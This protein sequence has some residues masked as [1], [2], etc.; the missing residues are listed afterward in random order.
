MTDP[1]DQADRVMAQA[2]VRDGERRAAAQQAARKPDCEDGPNVPP[3]SVRTPEQEAELKEVHAL[4]V[5]ATELEPHQRRA[6]IVYLKALTGVTT[7]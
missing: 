6:L 4:I 1:R 5:L 7:P 3:A 2:I